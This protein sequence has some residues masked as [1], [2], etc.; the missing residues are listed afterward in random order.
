MILEELEKRGKVSSEEHTS[1]LLCDPCFSFFFLY[2]LHLRRVLINVTCCWENKIHRLNI[3][4]S[5]IPIKVCT[6]AL[7][8]I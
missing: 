3:E 5:L 8:I 1:I 6:F 2:S 4:S 7:T